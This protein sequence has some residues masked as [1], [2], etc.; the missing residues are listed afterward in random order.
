MGRRNPDVVK[1]HR[2]KTLQGQRELELWKIIA[3]EL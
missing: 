3:Q 1:E 2:P